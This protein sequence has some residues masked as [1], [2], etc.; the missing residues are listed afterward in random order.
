[1]LLTF[2]YINHEKIKGKECIHV[3][4]LH[5]LYTFVCANTTFHLL[6]TIRLSMIILDCDDVGIVISMGKIMVYLSPIK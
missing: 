3:A 4:R 5:R 1:M 6:F 2:W